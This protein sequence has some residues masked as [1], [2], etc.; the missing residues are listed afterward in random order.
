[1]PA[2][3]EDLLP[4]G[5]VVPATTH[6]HPRCDL[7]ATSPVLS[8]VLGNAIRESITANSLRVVR[9]NLHHTQGRTVLDTHV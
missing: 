1:M 7:T 4:P 3:K 6:S 2:V 5:R 8:T 9:A